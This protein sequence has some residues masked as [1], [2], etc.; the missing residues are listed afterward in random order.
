MYAVLLGPQADTLVD[1]CSEVDVLVCAAGRESNAWVGRLPRLRELT[2]IIVTHPAA[3]AGEVPGL[4]YLV[5]SGALAEIVRAREEK[6]P[7]LRK[8]DL[9]LNEDCQDAL[10]SDAA[11][12]LKRAGSEGGVEITFHLY[13]GE[14]SALMDRWMDV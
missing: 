7:C 10:R 12:D 14:R 4:S 3:G 9:W 13:K 8:I 6:Q 5:E 1:A 2:L 11:S